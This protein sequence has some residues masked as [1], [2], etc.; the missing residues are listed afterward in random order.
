[1]IGAEHNDEP[2]TDESHARHSNYDVPPIDPATFTAQLDELRFQISRYL[3]VEA[4]RLR[5][6]VRRAVLW[7]VLVVCAGAVAV[8]GLMTAVVLLLAGLS[9]LVARLLGTGPWAG[10]LIVGTACLGLLGL[11]GWLGPRYLNRISLAR[12]RAKHEHLRRD[13]STNA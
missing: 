6:K 12:T 3:A 11:A 1:V 4:D 10:G 13:H 2:F 5:L 9:G 7:A 8:T